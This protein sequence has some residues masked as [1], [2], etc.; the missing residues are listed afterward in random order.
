VLRSALFAILAVLL[1]GCED[2]ETGGVQGS[3]SDVKTPAGVY[4]G[5]EIIDDCQL[6]YPYAVR[7]TGSRW[8]NDVAPGEPGR[9]DAVRE[10]GTSV[11]KPALADIKSIGGIGTGT[12]CAANGNG[13]VTVIMSNWRD[14]DGLFV[15][16]GQVLAERDLREEVS[17]RVTVIEAE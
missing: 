16:T 6:S 9:T 2:E 3:P 13:G 8:Y 5:Y 15:I 1:V 4:D 12:S 10:L 17:I 7:G 14:V 11:L